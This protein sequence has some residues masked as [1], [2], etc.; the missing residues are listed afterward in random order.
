[1]SSYMQRYF[2]F[3]LK[4]DSECYYSCW[5]FEVLK[6]LTFFPWQS[7]LV[8]EEPNSD[9]PWW[10]CTSFIQLHSF[11]CHFSHLFIYLAQKK[12]IF[13][14]NR[15][16]VFTVLVKY[17]ESMPVLFISYHHCF[18][19]WM[20]SISSREWMVNLQI[21]WPLRYNECD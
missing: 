18:S 8:S 20:P 11:K 5:V 15:T 7:Y 6:L 17:S 12:N 2:A 14:G 13:F 3:F 19:H 9:L 10:F 21:L 4:R 16:V 1:M